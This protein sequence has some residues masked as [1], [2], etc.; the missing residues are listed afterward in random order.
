MFS[1]EPSVMHVIM[2]TPLGLLVCL[3]SSVVPSN[4]DFILHRS[5]EWIMLMLGESILSLLIVDVPEEDSGYFNTFYCSLMTVILLQYLHFR[6]QPHHADGHALRRDK[7]AGIGFT[8][9][10]FIY[11]AALVALGAAYT[12]FVLEFSYEDSRRLEWEERSLAGG[13]ESKYDAAERQQRSAHLFSASLT[14]VFFS[15]EAL[16]AL[17]VG[18]QNSKKRCVSQKTHQMNVKGVIVLIFRGGVIAFVATLSQWVTDA[19]KLAEIGLGVT[20]SQIL[21]RLLG[22]MYFPDHVHAFHTSV[23]DVHQA[24][25]DPE[26]NKWP[27]VTHARAEAADNSENHEEA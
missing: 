21:L 20:V 10:Q 4:I 2:L 19:E 3:I 1:R 7:N 16:S 14:I 9:F 5:S 23:D 11:S 15:L 24:N 27:N 17:H 13:N 12:L 26:E 25:S 18:I 8:W 22:T 6:S